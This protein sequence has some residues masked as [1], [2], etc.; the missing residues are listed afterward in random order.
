MKTVEIWRRRG[1]SWELATK[2]GTAELGERY[3]EQACEGHLPQEIGVASWDDPGRAPHN[4]PR[5]VVIRDYAHG[6]VRYRMIVPG[7]Q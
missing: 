3:I 1:Q 5:D 2:V 4:D 6:E 7:V